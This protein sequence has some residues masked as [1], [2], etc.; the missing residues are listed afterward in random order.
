[1]IRRPPRSTLFPYTT[2]FRSVFSDP[3]APVTVTGVA[4]GNSGG[5]D[6]SGQVGT[7]IAGTYGFLSVD[8]AGHY[9]YTL[10][11]GRDNTP[12]NTNHANTPNGA[13]CFK[14]TKMVRIDYTS[15][16]SIFNH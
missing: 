15:A 14:I 6:V 9:T 10:T 1:M 12:V 7:T 11:K 4:A 16:A 13:V 3:D 2:L 5:V 8:S